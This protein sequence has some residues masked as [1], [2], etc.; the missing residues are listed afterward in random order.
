MSTPCEDGLHL[1]GD[2]CPS[3]DKRDPEVIKNYIACVGSL[4]YLSVFTRGVCSFTINQ[5]AHFLNNPGTT[6][7]SDVKR[8]LR[9][10][11][12]ECVYLRRIMEQIGYL[13]NSPTLIAQYNMT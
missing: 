6:H 10:C 9:Y 3:K 4:M 13:Q 7:I 2:D 1:R 8:I 11:A 5:T 12:V